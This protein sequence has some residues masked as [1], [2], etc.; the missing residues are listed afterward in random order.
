M[1]TYCIRLTIWP[2]MATD[3]SCQFDKKGGSQ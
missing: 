2:I 1:M 3:R